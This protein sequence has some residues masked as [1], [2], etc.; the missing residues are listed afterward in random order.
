MDYIKVVLIVAKNLIPKT[1]SFNGKARESERWLCGITAVANSFT[2]DNTSF[3]ILSS[4]SVPLDVFIAAPSEAYF[5]FKIFYE[6]IKQC[7]MDNFN[8]VL[9]RAL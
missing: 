2:F 4:F 3:V 8:T 9:R 1:C 7:S 5:T 6:E